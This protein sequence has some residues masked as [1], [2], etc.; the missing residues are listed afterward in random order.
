MRLDHV[1]Y[2]T[3]P[4]H[5][6]DEVQRIGSKL[7]RSFVDGGIHPRF[8]TRN[9][10]LPLAG[11]AYVEVVS[12]LDHPSADSAPFRLAVNER[13]E[14][15]GGWLGW[16]VSVEDLA[17][18][19]DRLGRSGVSGHRIRPDGHDLRWRQIGVNDLRAEPSLPFFTCWEGDGSDHPSRGG[20]GGPRLST[21]SL[22]GS[23][24]RVVDW[25]GA[26]PEDLLDGL[27]VD[28]SP[29][30]DPGLV[31]VTFDTAHGPVTID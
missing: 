8:G 13:A 1:S 12:V 19:E 18:V 11:G 17:P 29:D 28:W 9:F 25:L 5:L 22:A 3:S 26:A 7:Q 24:E 16:V 21:L 27:T 23:P 20:E 31:S 30:E 4:A 10:V 2:A 6:A 14:Q 15:G